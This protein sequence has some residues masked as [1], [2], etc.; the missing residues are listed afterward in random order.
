MIHDDVMHN[1]KWQLT[2]MQIPGKIG[3]LHEHNRHC[4]SCLIILP[5][6]TF[7]SQVYISIFKVTRVVKTDGRY[8][9]KL[10]ISVKTIIIITQYIARTKRKRSINTVG[11]AA[12]LRRGLNETQNKKLP[13]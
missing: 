10:E 8:K 9:K 12:T 3:N 7:Q 5:I 11:V 4:V 13:N 6:L 2:Y 1:G